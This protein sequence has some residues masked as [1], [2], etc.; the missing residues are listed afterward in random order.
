LDNIAPDLSLADIRGYHYNFQSIEMEQE[1]GRGATSVVYKARLKGKVVAVKKM[2]MNDVYAIADDTQIRKEEE[3]KQ[4]HIFRSEA[5]VLK[6]LAHPN[7]VQFVGI[8]KNPPALITEYIAYGNLFDAFK[9]DFSK[10]WTWEHNLKILVD[11]AAGMEF[12]HL[13]SPP[14]LHRDLKTPNIMLASLDPKDP[15]MAKIT[16]FGLGVSASSFAGRAVDNPIWLA[17]EVI[18]GKEYTSKSDVYS[19]GIISWET[20]THE[21]PFSAAG[22]GWF[23]SIEAAIL[24]G[25]R[26]AIPATMPESLSILIKACWHQD[27]AIRPTFTEIL[28]KLMEIGKELKIPLHIARSAKTN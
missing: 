6:R 15:V 28:S 27:V 17:V 13:T 11:I 21:E 12:L 5:W 10:S 23:V 2:L 3:I 16:D 1:L 7:V 25:E 24:K 9:K 8:C 18:E 20:A 19:F 14:T 22:Y 4:F 26:P